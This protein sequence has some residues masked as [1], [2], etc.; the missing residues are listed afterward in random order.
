MFLLQGHGAVQAQDLQN[1]ILENCC[2]TFP[3]ASE[4]SYVKSVCKTQGVQ[5]PA[6]YVI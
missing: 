3:G 5:N 6:V 1:A 2:V 4:K